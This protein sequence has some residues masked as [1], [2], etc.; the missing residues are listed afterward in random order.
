MRCFQT[1]IIIWVRRLRASRGYTD[2]TDEI[3]NPIFPTDH[4]E[5]FE[6]GVFI[7]FEKVPIVHI[8]E[9]QFWETHGS[10]ALCILVFENGNVSLQCS[11]K[12]PEDAP[13]TQ[14]RKAWVKDALR[15]Q[16][17]MPEFRNSTDIIEI[18][19]TALSLIGVTDL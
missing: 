11:S 16:G 8:S 13:E 6:Y 17:R 1:L 5:D 19:P 7:N 18:C 4:L 14:H 15:Q 2:Y 12:L 10:S 3:N 9:I